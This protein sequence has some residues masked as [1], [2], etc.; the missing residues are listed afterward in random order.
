[1]YSI[2]RNLKSELMSVKNSETCIYIIC[3]GYPVKSFQPIKR[4]NI[5]TFLRKYYCGV[6]SQGS[7]LIFD[8]EKSGISFYPLYKNYY[9]NID[10]F[11]SFGFS[12]LF[13]KCLSTFPFFLL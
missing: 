7:T 4:S 12:F 5:D 9:K 11:S 2:C 8:L 1:M 3:N 6:G 10:K 13:L